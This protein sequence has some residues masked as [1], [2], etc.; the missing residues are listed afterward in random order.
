VP[1]GPSAEYNAVVH[2]FGTP[3]RFD[4]EPLAHD[5]IGERRGW[6][7]F[8]RATEL[9]GTRFSVSLGAVARLERALIDFMLDLHINEHKYVEVRPPLLVNAKTLFGTGNLPK[10]EEDLFR[11]EPHGYY[12]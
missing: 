9:A 4:F 11:V 12:L 2:S 5:E 8:R 7:D 6:L 1:D 3:R 10:F